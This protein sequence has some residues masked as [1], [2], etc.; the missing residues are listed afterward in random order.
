MSKIHDFSGGMFCYTKLNTSSCDFLP[1][2]ILQKMKEDNFSQ[3]GDYDAPFCNNNTLMGLIISFC[4]N[5]N[6]LIS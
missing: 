1:P 5:S 3:F 2:L 6:N 4:S